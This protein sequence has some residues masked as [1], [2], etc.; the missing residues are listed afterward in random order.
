MNMKKIALIAVVCLGITGMFSCGEERDFV[1]DGRKFVTFIDSVKKVSERGDNGVGGITVQIAL[2]TGHVSSSIGVDFRT[3]FENIEQG[4]DPGQIEVITVRPVI[5]GNT[6]FGDIELQF[7]DDDEELAA[8]IVRKVNLELISASENGYVVGYPA[9]TEDY[10]FGRILSLEI[11]D[12]DCAPNSLGLWRNQNETLVDSDE[13]NPYP[14]QVFDITTNVPDNNS[15]TRVSIP[16]II[17]APL[18]DNEDLNQPRVRISAS[19]EIQG[20]TG[21]IRLGEI[22]SGDVSVPLDDGTT[23]EPSVTIT[24]LE[25]SYYDKCNNTITLFYEHEDLGRFGTSR[26]TSTLSFIQ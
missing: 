16:D 9:V 13:G 12:D 18:Y 10:T 11:L 2:G 26:A 1:Y 5:A 21:E 24:L 19:I 17:A 22:F 6:S 25:G 15:F 8:G 3:T 20:S 7:Y 4:T 23:E 14:P